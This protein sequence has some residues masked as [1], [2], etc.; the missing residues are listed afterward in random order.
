MQRLDGLFGQI[1]A[2]AYERAL[3][4]LPGGRS[5]PRARTHVCLTG[6]SAKLSSTEIAMSMRPC[7]HHGD[8]PRTYNDLRSRGIA[9][10]KDALHAFLDL[11]SDSERVRQS[12]PRKV[13][14]PGNGDRVLARSRKASSDV[15][16]LLEH[17]L[18]RAPHGGAVAPRGDDRHAPGG[19]DAPHSRWPHPRRTWLWTLKQPGQHRDRLSRASER[20]RRAR[21]FRPGTSD[22]SISRAR[23]QP[24]PSSH[25]RGAATGASVRKST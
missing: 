5:A 12:N 19:G 14:T 11:A 4:R 22:G 3:L 23:R 6:S 8:A 10:S 16:F 2:D 1:V 17:R 7:A 18:L 25:V 20:R 9:V 15:G 21:Q 13:S 24:T